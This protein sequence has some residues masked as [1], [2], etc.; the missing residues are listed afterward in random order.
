MPIAVPN[1]RSPSPTQQNSPRQAP[2][3]VY[4][5]MAAAQMH[6]EGRL[7]QD[8]AP[9]IDETQNYSAFS[10]ALGYKDPPIHA[11]DDK[12]YP[13]NTDAEIGKTFDQ[14]YGDKV[15]PF[16]EPG[17]KLNSLPTQEVLDRAILPSGIAYQTA[18]HVT[19][20]P[21][22]R[23]QVLKNW[24]AAQKS[25]VA[26]LGF[27]PRVTI[28]TNLAPDE[29]LTLAGFYRP[30]TDTLWYST[31]H[32]DTTVH[33]S[34]HR[35]IEQLRKADALPQSFKDYT[36]SHGNGEEFVVRAMMVK[37]LGDVELGAGKLNDEQVRDAKQR[38]NDPYFRGPNNTSGDFNKMI[39]DL[40]Q[41]AS[42]YIAQ[43]HPMGPH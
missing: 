11:I 19:A 36:D 31:D 43:K 28:H 12:Q 4:A 5:L 30:R 37:H 14:T 16:I 3:D 7:I 29:K 35:G 27:D 1:S 42:T 15:A 9:P 17:A 38:M 21:E 33:E 2:P 6:Y 20:S 22:E 8:A 10:K 24:Q 39:A 34:M 41:A 40:E 26:A 23:D 13:G 32:E 25:P 18:D